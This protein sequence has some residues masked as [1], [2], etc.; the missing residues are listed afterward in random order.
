[1]CVKKGN[2]EP[3]KFTVAAGLRMLTRKYDSTTC[4]DARGTPA[5]TIKDPY[6]S[7]HIQIR[8]IS[9]DNITHTCKHRCARHPHAGTQAPAAI[10]EE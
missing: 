4:E 3:F 1:M 5:A 9:G 2:G 8:A 7:R 10:A 6:A